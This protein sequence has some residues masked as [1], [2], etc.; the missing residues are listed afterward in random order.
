MM[1]GGLIV[2]YNPDLKILEKN[3]KRTMDQVEAC[4]IVDNGSKNADKIKHLGE[5]LGATLIVLKKNV[6]IAAAQNIGFEYFEKNNF[7]W[8]LTLD[9]DSLVPKNTISTY[10]QSKKIRNKTTG[11]ITSRYYD[12][13]WSSSQKKAIMGTTDGLLKATQKKFVIS[14]GNLVRVSAWKAVSGFDEFLFIDMVDYDF[15]AK[16]VLAGYKIWQ[17]NEIV[18]NHAVGKVL[19]KPIL[20]KILLLPET[21]LLADHPA[22]RQYYIYRN[23]IIFEKRFPMFGRKR[24]LILRSFIA[25]RRMFV[26]K[27]TLSK[28]KASWRGIIDGARYDPQKDKVFL[29]T[30]EIIKKDNR[31]SDANE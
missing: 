12:R 29:K 10:L 22:F 6:G 26:Y 3:I 15:D 25:T 20:E 23:S 5:K 17:I 1:I 4:V 27:N 30:I 18:M 31:R 11:I 7:D 13:N 19:H 9:Q 8:V 16:L 14:S 24:F 28:F 21:G 2:T